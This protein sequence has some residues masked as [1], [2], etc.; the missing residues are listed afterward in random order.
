MKLSRARGFLDASWSVISAGLLIEQFFNCN[1]DPHDRFLNDP[2]NLL[3]GD[4]IEIRC[5]T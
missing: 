4:G 3:T 1:S 2:K 5:R